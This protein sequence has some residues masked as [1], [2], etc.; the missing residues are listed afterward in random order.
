MRRNRRCDDQADLLKTVQRE[1][2]RQ[3]RKVLTDFEKTLRCVQTKNY[4]LTLQRKS[5]KIY[6]LSVTKQGE[7][8]IVSYGKLKGRT[9]DMK[10]IFDITTFGAVDD[11]ITDSTQAIQ[12]ALDAAGEVGGTVIVPPGRFVCGG[13]KIPAKISVQSDHAW[14]YRQNSSGGGVLVLRDA[15]DACMLDMSEAFGATIKGLTLYGGHTGQN[16]HGILTRHSTYGGGGQEDC[17]RIED[18]K[19]EGFTGD[20]LHYE[21]YWCITVRHCMIG[22]NSGFGFFMNGFDAF[23][24]DNWFSGNGRGGIGSTHGSSHMTVTGN[25]IECN[26]GPG[27]TLRCSKNC[28]F[29]GNCFDCNGGPGLSVIGREGD[30]VADSITVTGNVFNGSASWY[31]H[32]EPLSIYDDAHIRLE[33]CVNCIVS[34]NTF[35]ARN[36]ADQDLDG[37]IFPSRTF[38]IR[39]LRGCIIHHNIMQGGMRIS[40]VLDLG[41]HEDEIL[42]ESNIGCPTRELTPW[43]PTFKSD[44]REKR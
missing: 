10:R 42:L 22:Y 1:Q 32:E 26:N 31:R 44:K 33:R 21:Y 27:V 28:S 38:V 17:T 6:R 20:G 29:S 19:V 15:D 8:V 37:E 7:C 2:L 43:Y 13:L 34:D 9:N 16:V 24:L 11:G 41:E 5:C 4:P 14:A 35:R 36:K 12:A 30:D 40:P 39:Q 25:R 23:I 18:C 3:K